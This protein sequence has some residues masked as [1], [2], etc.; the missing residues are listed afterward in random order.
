MPAR[1]PV[2]STALSVQEVAPP[3]A[4]PSLFVGEHERIEVLRLAAPIVDP[5]AQKIAAAQQVDREA[6]VLVLVRE[7]APERVLRLERAQR[8]ERERLQT[9]RPK[10]SVRIELVLDMNLHARTELADVLLE[11]WLEKAGPQLAPSQPLRL[12]LVHPRDQ[13]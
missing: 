4:V 9:P 5:D 12:E 11:G 6:I 13:G 7:F 10:R 8:L 2:R 1:P 3:L